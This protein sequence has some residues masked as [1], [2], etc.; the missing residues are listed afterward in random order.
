MIDP[1]F[2]KSLKAH[3]NFEKRVEGNAKVSTVIK[4][5]SG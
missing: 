4:N 1:N 3:M 5:I 2:Y